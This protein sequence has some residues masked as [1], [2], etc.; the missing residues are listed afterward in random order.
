MKPVHDQISLKIENLLCVQV[1]KELKD[2]MCSKVFYRVIKQSWGR[3]RNDLY[4]QI[5]FQIKKHL[6]F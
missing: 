6:F 4:D 3:V 5:R 2:E 1:D